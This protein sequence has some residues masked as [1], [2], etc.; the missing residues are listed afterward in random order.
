MSSN[1]S[2]QPASATNGQP[3]ATDKPTDPTPQLGILEEDDEFEEFE[4]EDWNAAE[5]DE[6]A[7][8]LW[9]DNWDDDDIEDDFSQQLRAELEKQNQPQPMKL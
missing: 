2:A 6:H 7:E 4:A 5:E 8:N 3:A 1:K 9:D